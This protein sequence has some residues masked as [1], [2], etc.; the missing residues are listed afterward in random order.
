MG[1]ADL[2]D[3]PTW[4]GG[5]G[6]LTAG[7]FAYQ[8]IRSQRQQIGEQRAFIAEQM[9][10]MNDQRQNLELE[11]AALRATAEERKRA[12]AKQIHMDSASWRT[13]SVSGPEDALEVALRG[14]CV[15]SNRSDEPV[16]DLEVRIGEHAA[17]EVYDWEEGRNYQRGT[18]HEEPVVRRLAPRRAILCLSPVVTRETVDR[19]SEITVRFTDANGVRWSLNPTGDLEEVSADGAS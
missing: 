19:N 13:E 12:Q 9:R 16:A 8:T 18:R 10:F 7:W 15:L 6:A 2:G 11:R 1:P 14:R 4:L 17:T 5:A 3:V